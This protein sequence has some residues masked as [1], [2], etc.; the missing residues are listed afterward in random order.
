MNVSFQRYVGSCLELSMEELRTASSRLDLSAPNYDFGI[1][2]QELPYPPR[3]DTVM[4]R[5]PRYARHLV[6]IMPRSSRNWKR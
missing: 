3:S 1:D 6:G 5:G 4:M 2:W